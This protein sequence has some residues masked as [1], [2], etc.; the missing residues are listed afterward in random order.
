VSG[1]LPLSSEIARAQSLALAPV[2]GASA[3]SV[4]S[5]AT[6]VSVAAP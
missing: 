3:S 5:S 2:A 4:L 1:A 6:T